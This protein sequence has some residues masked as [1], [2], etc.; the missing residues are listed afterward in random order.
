MWTDVWYQCVLPVFE[1]SLASVNTVPQRKPVVLQTPPE[2]GPGNF[3]D[4]AGKVFHG[5]SDHLDGVR[6]GHLQE[7]QQGDYLVGRCST[8]ACCIEEQ[9]IVGPDC[10]SCSI[11][12]FD[13]LLH[14]AH[15]GVC[16]SVMSSP[17]DT[18]Q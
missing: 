1:C 7:V 6:C 15:V 12:G 18:S 2:S 8:K 10:L 14:P 16:M 3:V 17:F 4:A 13:S 11:C 5:P 9:T